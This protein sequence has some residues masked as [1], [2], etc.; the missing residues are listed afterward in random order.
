[1]ASSRERGKAKEERRSGGQPFEPLSDALILA[2]VERAERHRSAR[3]A[4]TAGVSFRDL[5]EHLGLVHGP[6]TTRRMRPHVERLRT[7]GLLA[8][9]RRQGSDWWSLTPAGAPPAHRCPP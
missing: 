1:V 3:L 6:W 7:A 2:A 4:D 9:T 5:V 8:R